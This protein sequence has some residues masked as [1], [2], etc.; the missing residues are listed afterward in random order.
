LKPSEV[1]KTES[2]PQDVPGAEPAIL[3]STKKTFDNGF[4]FAPWVYLAFS[5]LDYFYAPDWWFE[6]FFIRVGHW[7]FVKQ[8]QRLSRKYE[9]TIKT[10]R[11]IG[12]VWSAV[13]AWPIT[14]MIYVTQGITSPYYA[15]LNLVGALAIFFIPFHWPTLLSSLAIIYLPY[16]GIGLKQAISIPQNGIHLILNSGFILGSSIILLWMRRMG[17]QA[18]MNELKAKAAL[19]EEIRRRGEIIEQKTAENLK[20][21]Q[22]SSQFSPQIIKAFEQGHLRLDEPARMLLVS[23][24]FVDIVGSTEKVT[25]LPIED[26]EKVTNQ[27]IEDCQAVFLQH[28]LTL[29]KFLGDGFLALAGAPM[30][31]GGHA[32]E[33][34]RAAASLLE[35]IRTRKQEY[36]RFWQEPLQIRIGIATGTALT[37]FFGTHFGVKSYTGIGPTINLAARLCQNA[38][39]DSIAICRQTYEYLPK[40]QV[41]CVSLGDLSLKGF[42]KPVQVFH[43]QS[44]KSPT[45]QENQKLPLCP[46][47]KGRGLQLTVNS[48]G[49]WVYQCSQCGHELINSESV[50]NSVTQ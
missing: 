46:E 37:G 41:Q 13:A 50:M 3:E 30:G 1:L 31:Y 25:Q 14:Y 18:W 2:Q 21:K 34:A 24:I 7:L 43:L 19:D 42:Q 49:H 28:N 20:L 10:Y 17:H 27:F 6:F 22:L 36:S 35:R 15:G 44:I 26:Y 32:W 8:L 23:A 45:V 33:A 29:D 48:S 4:R 12:L 16:L 5:I 47:C 38:A 9:F 39:P 40:S 11:R